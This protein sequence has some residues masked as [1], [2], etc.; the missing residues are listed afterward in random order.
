MTAGGVSG[1]RSPH[2]AAPHNASRPDWYILRA[3]ILESIATSP[4]AFLATADEVAAQA[5]DFWR[6]RLE[7]ATWAVVQCQDKILGIAAVVPPSENDVYE[8]QEKAC[9]IESVWIHPDMRG[10]GV[11]ERLVT[12]LIEHK[13]Q[14]G[15]RKFYLWVLDRNTPALR[16]YDRMKFKPTGRHSKFP[17]SQ[18]V[19]E[20]DSDVIDVDELKWNADAREQDLRNL[21]LTYRLLAADQVSTYLP[22]RSWSLGR[23]TAG[24]M[25]KYLK[26]A[27]MESW[28]GRSAR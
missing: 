16:L 12:Y 26:A 8:L 25:S 5:P 10:H 14:A 11:G 3:T 21:Q 17:E 24:T 2:D 1:V 15:I 6:R 20:F 7:A 19:R 18:F 28:R 13:R 23:Q 22:R 9:F 4:G 27:M